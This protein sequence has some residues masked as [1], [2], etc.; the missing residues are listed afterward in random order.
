MI[1]AALSLLY[2]EHTP[3]DLVITQ[4][5]LKQVRIISALLKKE[6]TQKRKV[7]PVRKINSASP[8]L[9]YGSQKIEQLNTAAVIGKTADQPVYSVN[10]S[11][12]ISKY[13]G[14]TEKN[15]DTLFGTAEIKDWILFFDEA[16]TLF[17][18]R[19]DVKDSHDRYA[20]LDVNYLLQRIENFNGLI[21]IAGN[22][23][24]T[25]DPEILKRFR[26]VIHFPKPKKKQGQTGNQRIL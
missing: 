11:K 22:K 7:Q 17:G 23:K 5:A 12:L 20:N 1:K 4:K 14:E 9:F 19:T 16:D 24:T 2:T 13:I 6:T 15:L 26:S 21:F 3:D 18:K 10:L 25:I 8:V